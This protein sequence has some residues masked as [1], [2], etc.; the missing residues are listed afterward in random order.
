MKYEK[1]LKRIGHEGIESD[2]MLKCPAHE[3]DAASLHISRGDNGW[4]VFHCFAGCS[5]EEILE[6][7]GIPVEDISNLGCT[8]D[9][10]S[11]KT[12][13]PVSFLHSEF[14]LSDGKYKK[15]NAVR[16]PY[17]DENSLPL[18]DKFRVKVQFINADDSAE[19]TINVLRFTAQ[20]NK[21]EVDFTLWQPVFWI[22]SRNL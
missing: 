3:D 17:Q 12:R 19:Q 2:I 20:E 13:I 9:Q 14:G 18:G 5:Y 15:I 1:F 6:G 21:R 8:L 11:R 16:I 22:L 4:A 10:Y 7:F